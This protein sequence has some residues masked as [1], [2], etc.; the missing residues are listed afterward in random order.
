M[1]KRSLL[2]PAPGRADP[3]RAGQLTE[4]GG[5]NKKYQKQPTEKSAF[6]MP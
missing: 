4:L 1:W 2:R 3:A 6:F 5:F